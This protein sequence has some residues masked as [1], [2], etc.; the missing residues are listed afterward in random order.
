MLVTQSWLTLCNPMNC[1]PPGSSI[2]GTF[3]ARILE[4]TAIISRRSF[5]PR[6]RTQ[7]SRTAGRLFT[8]WATKEE[9]DTQCKK[10]GKKTRP[11]LCDPMDRIV[12]GFL[13]AGILGWVVYP[14]SSRSSQPRNQAGLLYCRQN[15]YQLSYEGSQTKGKINLK[16]FIFLSLLTFL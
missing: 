12:R 13:Q 8:I 16:T 15:H 2:H 3:Q 4:W 7:V 11:P 10:S 5:W 6:D 9:Q 14:F 1:T